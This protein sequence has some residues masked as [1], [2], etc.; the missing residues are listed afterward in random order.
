MSMLKVSDRELDESF[1]VRFSWG[2]SFLGAF[3]E[4][5]KSDYWICH[6]CPSVLL[7]VLVEQLGSHWIDFHEIW[8]LDIFR[9]SLDKFQISSILDLHIEY[10]I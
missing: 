1:S 3:A 5:A 4:F 7:S 10:F 6:F 9:K 8:Y 2:G